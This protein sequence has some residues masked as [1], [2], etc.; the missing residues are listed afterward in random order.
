MYQG[1]HS[2]QRVTSSRRILDS[3]SDRVY[4]SIESVSLTADSTRK[5]EPIAKALNHIVVEN[6]QELRTTTANWRVKDSI[7]VNVPIGK[8]PKGGQTKD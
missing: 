4:V 7:K 3:G 6:P 2:T 8:Q 1:P 5:G